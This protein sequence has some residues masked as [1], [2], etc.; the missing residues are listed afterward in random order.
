MRMQ[1]YHRIQSLEAEVQR[2]RALKVPT[3]ED[4]NAQQQHDEGP[5]G[6]E[7]A[8]RNSS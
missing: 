3:A 7:A 4:A 1:I 5:I 6:P 8:Q 2:L